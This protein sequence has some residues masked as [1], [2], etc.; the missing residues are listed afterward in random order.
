MATST[1]FVQFLAVFAVENGLPTDVAIGPAYTAFEQLL[2][3]AEL[4]EIST[5]FSSFKFASQTAID[6]SDSIS[7]AS[8]LAN[9]TPVLI[10]LVVGG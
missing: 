8:E 7:S 5:G 2:G 6:A 3:D 1:E 9:T 4:A 10:Q